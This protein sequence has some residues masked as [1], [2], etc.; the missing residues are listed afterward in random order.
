MFGGVKS[1]PLGALPR[2]KTF[3]PGRCIPSKSG[4]RNH[5]I[6]GA[7]DDFEL[8]GAL[9]KQLPSRMEKE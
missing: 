2:C 7:T 8:F 1:G 6:R 3:L 4:A 5:Q 9:N